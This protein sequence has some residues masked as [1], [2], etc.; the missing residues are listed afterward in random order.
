MDTPA[1]LKKMVGGDLI[2]LRTPYLKETKGFIED[3]FNLAVYEYGE[4]LQIEVSGGESF[5]PALAGQLGRR[6]DSISLR[7]PTLDDVFLKLTGRDIREE[8]A[9]S[10]SFMRTHI[11]GRR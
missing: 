7:R 2:T 3:R 6:I 11:R 5:I 1:N 10:W 8:A 9:D 4:Y